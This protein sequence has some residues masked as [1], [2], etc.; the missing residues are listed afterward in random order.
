MNARVLHIPSNTPTLEGAAPVMAQLELVE[1]RL[2]AVVASQVQVASDMA[3]R[4]FSAGGKRVRPTLVVLSALAAGGKADDSRMI[5][6]AAAA[7]LVH[8]AS[9]IHDD[10]VDETHERRGAETANHTWGNK[11]SV[12]GGDYL[13]SKA[14]LL[15]A[16]VGNTEILKALSRT[17]VEM[18]ESEMLQATSEGSIAAWEEH[19]WRIIRG[20][21][22][23]FMGTCC[24]C[25]AILAGAS[26]EVR[27]ALLEYGIELGLAFQITDDLLDVDGD[28]ARTGKEIGADL[29]HGKFTLPVLLALGKLTGEAR[30]EFA[31][32]VSRE[33]MT[34]AEA[35]SVAA[36]LVECGAAEDAR[37]TAAECVRTAREQL[38][39]LPD[40]EYRESLESLASSITRRRA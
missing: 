28:P 26:A 37:R 32:A 9:L 39:V 35:R 24:E 27:E 5:D 8:S 40:S 25:G 15:L 10:V 30:R 7:E 36:M 4:L 13:L 21:T 6:L 11:L 14:F 38:A 18:T 23:S 16:D 33:S 17:A 19:Y 29:T 3:S 20:K 2:E 22:A 1:R 34:L 31:T 12:L